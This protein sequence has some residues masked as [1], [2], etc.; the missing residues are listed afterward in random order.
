MRKTIKK[1]LYAFAACIVTDGV[2]VLFGNLH[3]L[4]AVLTMG[5]FILL[6]PDWKD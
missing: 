5:C 1:I 3:L 2:Y 6:Q 4:S